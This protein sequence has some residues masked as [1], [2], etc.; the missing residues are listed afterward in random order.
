VN[1]FISRLALL[2]MLITL[3]SCL[4]SGISIFT[5]IIRAAIVYLGVLFTFF[6]AGIILRWGIPLTAKKPEVKES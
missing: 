6:I 4:I 1:Q 2:V 3:V 5:S